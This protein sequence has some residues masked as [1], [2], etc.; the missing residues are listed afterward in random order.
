MARKAARLAL[1][2]FPP[3]RPA[4]RRSALASAPAAPGPPPMTV[5]SPSL[6]RGLVGPPTREGS[7]GS[8]SCE[9]RGGAEGEET[10]DRGQESE[11][12]SSLER[13]RVQTLFSTYP[14]PTERAPLGP[15]VDGVGLHDQATTLWE[16]RGR[17]G[18]SERGGAGRCAK[19]A[20]LFFLCSTHRAN[21][22]ARRLVLHKVGTGAVGT[23]AGVLEAGRVLHFYG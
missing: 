11:K 13:E 15:L 16:W 19:N 12:R 6:R 7:A 23:G 9:R 5:V 4:V 22:V 20:F 8:L 1:S 14:I 18:L 17:K 2:S 10:T 3:A 21:E